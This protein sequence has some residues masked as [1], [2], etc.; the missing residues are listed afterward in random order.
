MP[1]RS[2]PHRPSATSAL[3]GMMPARRRSLLLLTALATLAGALLLALDS[4]PAQAQS[5]PTLSNIIFSGGSLPADGVAFGAGETIR[6]AVG[7]RGSR[8]AVTG[9]PRIAILIGDTTRYATFAGIRGRGSNWFVDFDYTVQPGDRDR[10]GVSVPAGDI[11]L[12]GGTISDGANAA[13]RTHSGIAAD[14]NRKV[15]ALGMRVSAVTPSPVQEGGSGT[16][17][18]GLGKQ[19]ASDVVI[20]ISSDNTDVTVAPAEITFTTGNWDTPQTVTVRVGE[21]DDYLDETATLAHSIDD[22]SS[23]DAYDPVAD[24]DLTVNVDDDDSPPPVVRRMGVDLRTNIAFYP[25]D[26]DGNLLLDEAVLLGEGHPIAVDVRFSEA[27]TVAGLPRIAL[28]IGGVTRYAVYAPGGTDRKV[29]SFVYTPQHPDLDL[30]GLETGD[31]IE[32]PA[33]STDAECDGSDA[34]PAKCVAASIVS[35][36]TGTA[37][38]LNLGAYAFNRRGIPEYQLYHVD[39][40]LPKLQEATVAGTTLTLTYDRSLFEGFDPAPDV[41]TVTKTA[42]SSTITVTGVSVSGKTVVLTLQDAVAP[43][44]AVTVAY[45]EPDTG[46]RLLADVGTVVGS[47]FAASFTGQAVANLPGIIQIYFNTD[48]DYEPDANDTYTAGETVRV[49]VEFVPRVDVSGIPRL[50]IVVGS[51]TRYAT[52]TTNFEVNLFP[53]KSILY[54]D[55]TF[56]EGDT[57]TDGISV[58]AGALDLNGATITAENRSGTPLITHSGIAAD[59]TRKVDAPCD[60]PCFS[61]P[62][63][64]TRSVDEN[65]AAGENIGEVLTVQTVDADDTL[66][67]S[68]GG[69][70]ANSFDFSATRATIQLKTKAPLD[71]E[72]KPSYSVIVSATDDNDP[73]ATTTITVTITVTDVNEPPAK[74]AVTSRSAIIGST[75]TYTFA[76]AVDP[77]G[78]ALTYTAT[79]PDGSNLPTWLTFTPA[80]RTFSATPTLDDRGSVTIKVVA[81]DGSLQ[82]E[83]ELTITART[84]PP[85]VSTGG[86]GPVGPVSEPTTETEKGND[87]A[88]TLTTVGEGEST[89]TVEIGEQ[90]IE[91]EVSV[92]EESVG[93]QLTLPEDE[94]LEEL[95]EIEFSTVAEADAPEEPRGFRIAGDDAIVDITLRD[96]DGAEIT[97][98]ETAATV[99]LPVSEETLA[100]AGD[101]SLELLHYDED[102]GWTALPEAELRTDADGGSLLCAEADR[103]SRFA[104][105]VRLADE[106]G[107]EALSLGA[108]T[109]SPDF[110]AEQ[111]AYEATVAHGAASVTITADTAHAAAR[112]A[113]V[114]A[115]ADPD[116]PGHQVALAVGTNLIEVTVTAE[117]GLATAVYAVTV[118]RAAPALPTPPPGG[119]TEGFAGTSEIR[120]LIAGQPFAVATVWALDPATQEWQSYIPGAPDFVNTLDA[121]LSPGRVVIMRRG[122]ESPAGV[123]SEVPTAPLE[124]PHGVANVLPAPPPGGWTLGV[125]GT[126]DPAVLAAA[127]PFAV[128]MVALR[129]VPSQRWLMYIPGALDVAQTLT[130]GLLQPHSI[131][132]LR[133]APEPEPSAEA[134]TGTEAG[135]GTE[136]ETDT[137]AVATTYTVV[138]GDTLSAIAARFGLPTGMLA[139]ANGIDDPSLIVV[140]R[141]LTIPPPPAAVYTVV[142]GDTLVGIASRLG[143]SYEDLVAINGIVDPDTI[144]PGQVLAVPERTR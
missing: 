116:A 128:R 77:D 67:W 43:N 40:R 46:N 78:D 49:N 95:A 131:V 39:A 63:P 115:D 118:T 92:D 141:V 88:T 109:L 142:S 61:G 132:W 106:A 48:S 127:Q 7:Y 114:P 41:F 10:D 24:L 111:T 84:A 50:P 108:P 14:P 2:W 68:L 136:T 60:K 105:G 18:V 104:V 85:P 73:P 107:L 100:E 90:S 52:L 89:I 17:T 72:T 138:S 8:P 140:G 37:A 47:N 79:R 133:A 34:Q 125:S 19:P 83:A 96:E 11:D 57:D 45:T 87:G 120:A 16:Y 97:E 56:Q 137:E 69:T 44:E 91:V 129:H 30:D 94:A 71:H 33:A 20:N 123:P 144:F 55:Y 70:D 122:G 124:A 22:Q 75:L 9:T 126:N 110:A 1:H 4:G 117:D 64:A 53:N 59:A 134:E 36:D 112:V 54:F 42:D 119:W 113:I 13:G 65:T 29:L 102:E 74:P 135:T 3:S 35:M 62:D 6:V 5:G 93:V 58:A 25:Y 51:E 15:A 82:S 23:D 99:C 12:N 139:A 21:D 26:G 98:L 27:V 66:T 101:R 103:F 31:V 32:L 130:R 76:P 81:S 38:D 86:G 143:I 80:T 121:A 28:D